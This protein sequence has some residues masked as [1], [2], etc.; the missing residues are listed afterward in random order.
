[1]KQ[2]TL[3]SLSEATL[4]SLKS[5]TMTVL[6]KL[7]QLKRLWYLSHRRP[8]KAQAILRIRAVSPEPSLFAHM[9]YASRRRVRPKLRHLALL[10]GC[11]CAFEEW[12]YGGRNL[13]RWLKQKTDKPQ[14]TRREKARNS[15][16]FIEFSPVV[17]LI[18]ATWIFRSH[19]E[20]KQ[21]FIL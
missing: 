16:Y 4:K 10:D 1:M 21:L 17:L 3:L 6:H 8:A 11:A 9:K 7:S 19:S 20:E 12:V 13:M 2:I 5:L 14:G 15:S 18:S